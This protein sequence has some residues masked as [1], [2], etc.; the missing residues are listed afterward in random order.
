[1]GSLKEIYASSALYV[2]MDT[3]ALNYD[4]LQYGLSYISYLVQGMFLRLTIQF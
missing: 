1:M 4:T 3:A 2:L